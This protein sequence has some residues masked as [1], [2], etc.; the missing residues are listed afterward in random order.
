MT[1]T[2]A[3]RAAIETISP[4][5]LDVW[6]RCQQQFAFVYFDGRRRPPSAAM[7]AGSAFDATANQSYVQQIAT[8]DL[9]SGEDVRGQFATSWDKFRRDVVE[10]GEEKPGDILDSGTRASAAWRRVIAPA[11]RAIRVQVP[12]AFRVDTTDEADRTR[13][14]ALG[15]PDVFDL[16]GF[17]D[18]EADVGGVRVIVDNKLKGKSMS[19]AEATR[20]LQPPV[21]CGATGT[22]ELQLHVAIR[23][24]EPKT[25]VIRVAVGQTDIE[26]AR[27]IAA[28]ARRAIAVAARTGDVLPNRQHVMCSRRWCAFWEDC[29]KT[30][31]G[32][33][34]E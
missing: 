15:I 14:A 10:W 2:L 31:G 23:T 8:G 4:S 7:A 24:K 16:H 30:H 1:L 21:Y 26:Y 25:Q 9:P 19:D 5:K 29:Q 20:S 28:R 17:A 13:N 6:L 12:V 11:V 27:R 34:A 32:T 18:L 22:S 3:Q 33:V